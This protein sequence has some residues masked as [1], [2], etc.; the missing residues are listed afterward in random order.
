MLAN[1]KAILMISI[2]FI[3]LFFFQVNKPDENSK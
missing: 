3:Y 1:K 2:L